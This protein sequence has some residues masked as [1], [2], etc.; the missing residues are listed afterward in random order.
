MYIVCGSITSA[1]QLAK[2][3]EG[4]SGIPALV[5][6]T[7]MQIKKG[8][9]SYSIKTDFC[10]IDEIYKLSSSTGINIKGIYHEQRV[11]NRRVYND[12]S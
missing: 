4:H 6:H 1:L 2:A 3:I 7:P 12:I 11:G 8:G 9:C 10:E 5:I